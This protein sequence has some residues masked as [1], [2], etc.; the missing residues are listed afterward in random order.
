MQMDMTSAPAEIERIEGLLYRVGYD[1]IRFSFEMQDTTASATVEDIPWG[2]WTLQVDAYNSNNV[3][4]YTGSVEVEI[5]PG[6]ITPVSLTLNPT[7]GGLQITVNWGYDLQKDLVAYYPF[8]GNADDY[9]GNG[10]NGIVYG[11]TITE[12]RK[13][14]FNSAYQF[15]GNDDFIDVGGYESLRI[16]GD[17]TVALWM[18]VN[19]FDG[20]AIGILTQ[21]ADNTDNPGTNALYRL[22]FRDSTRSLVY[23]HESG[24]GENNVYQFENTEFEVDRWYHIAIVR[25]AVTKTVDLYVNGENAGTYNYTSNPDNGELS[26]LRIGENQGTYFPGRFFNGILDEIYI[27]SRILMQKEV[28]ELY[29]Q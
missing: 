3:V 11:A 22:N 7:T 25:N 5:K 9:S 27:Y 14:N 19:S 21:Q 24:Q 23:A 16:T 2:V 8:N 6:E 13:G 29:E 20:E 17:L 10:Y 4:I 15:D 28:Q 26:T 12:D 1:T 18:K